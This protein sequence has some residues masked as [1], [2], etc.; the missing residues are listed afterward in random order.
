MK[1]EVINLVEY[2][3]TLSSRVLGARI[4]S[5][6]LARI[7]ADS[8]LVLMFDFT[9]VKSMSSGF[10]YELFGNIRKR[11]PNDFTKRVKVKI[12]D[13]SDHLFAILAKGMFSQ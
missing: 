6:S 13:N 2:G 4:S 11:L 7:K 10:S 5:E 8:N 3:D 1:V 12:P 9:G